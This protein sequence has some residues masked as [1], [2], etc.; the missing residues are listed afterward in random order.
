MNPLSIVI[1]NEQEQE[2]EFTPELNTDFVDIF[3][4]KNSPILFGCRTGICGTCAVVVE[5]EEEVDSQSEAE[6][7]FFHSIEEHNPKCRLACQMKS[8]FNYKLKK[9]KV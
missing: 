9:I 5:N 4:A 1:K 7:E 3:D 2:F 6:K 8:N